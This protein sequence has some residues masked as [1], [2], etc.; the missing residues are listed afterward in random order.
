MRKHHTKN[1]GDLG[2]LHAQLD[3]AQRG[4]TVLLPLTEHEAF[5]LVAYRD[6]RFLRIQ[7][8]YRAAVDNCIM[9]LFSTCWADRHGTHTTPID[10]EAVDLMCIYCPDTNKCYYIE[11]KR[12]HRTGIRLRLVGT[13]NNQKKHV[14]DAEQFTKISSQIVER[15]PRP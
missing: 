4:F 7:V 5:D 3:L 13:R 1:K 8:K 12:H 14:H 6:G 2:V 10:K 9:V 11:P 15:H